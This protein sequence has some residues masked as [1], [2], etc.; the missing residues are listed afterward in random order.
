VDLDDRYYGGSRLVIEAENN[1]D[2]NPYIQSAALNGRPLLKTFVEHEDL[3]DNGHLVF[4]MGP[5]P[6]P[7]WGT[8]PGA[9]P[10]SMTKDEPRFVY[11]D[12]SAPARAKPDEVVEVT[13]QVTNQGGVGTA[14]T[15]LWRSD[16]NAHYR[17]GHL[18][19]EDYSVLATGETRQLRFEVPLYYHGVTTFKIGDLSAEVE[20][21]RIDGKDHV[22][23][24]RFTP[25]EEQ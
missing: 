5:S 7:E 1:A 18:V 8:G 4:R 25:P 17:K 6:N 11:E 24:N 20:L 16:R 22:T 2:A 14:Y 3:V 12:M 19:G 21:P 13:V 15:Q 9:A 10:Y 23:P